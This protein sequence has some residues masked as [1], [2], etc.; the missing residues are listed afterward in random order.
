[1]SAAVMCLFGALSH[2]FSMDMPGGEL[3]CSTTCLL[4]VPLV[5]PLVW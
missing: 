3:W 2:D 5:P 4:G 1:M